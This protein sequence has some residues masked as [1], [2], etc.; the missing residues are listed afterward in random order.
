M[1]AVA[2]SAGGRAMAYRAGA[3]GAHAY[4]TEGA[5]ST[6]ARPTPFCLT[7]Q[8]NLLHHGQE[9]PPRAALLRCKVAARGLCPRAMT[10]FVMLR[11]TTLDV[12]VPWLVQL[13]ENCPASELDMD[14][15][16]RMGSFHCCRRLISNRTA[17]LCATKHVHGAN[18]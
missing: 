3:H 5:G 12:E 2:Y 18:Y 16:H 10:L 8:K 14:F 6:G 9:K 17:Y 1:R 11:W 4:P 15:L 13:E 7:G